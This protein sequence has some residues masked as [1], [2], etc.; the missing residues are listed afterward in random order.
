VDG[1]T[2]WVNGLLLLLGAWVGAALLTWSRR[3]P[4]WAIPVALAMGTVVVSCDVYFAGRTPTNDEMFYTWIAFYAAYFL[5]P[6]LAALQIAA[7]VGERFGADE[8][9]AL[10]P[11]L[12]VDRALAS[13]RRAGLV[14]EDRETHGSDRYR[15]KHLLMRDVAYAGLPKAS[16]ADLHESFGAQLERSVGDR[17]DEFAEVLAHHAERAFTLSV[18]VRSSRDLIEGRARRA[19]GSIASRGLIV[20]RP[21]HGQEPSRWV[22]VER[23]P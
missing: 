21:G 13:L 5:R 3:I 10:A 11:D 14:L 18:E 16:R 22:A 1:D 12:D 23:R 7:V 20:E 15:F 2:L 4:E 9:Q 19:L 17:R 6:S 8:L